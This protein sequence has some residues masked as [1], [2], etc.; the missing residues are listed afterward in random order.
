MLVN[1]WNCR[2]GEDEMLR[3]NDLF[4]G[5]G[6]MG[7]GFKQ[8]GF[9]LAGA[10][11][12]DKYAVESYGHNISPKVKQDDITTMKWHHLPYAEVWT[13]GFPC[14]DISVAGKQ[15][16]MIKG[17]TRSG[18][19]YEV[20]RLLDETREHLSIALPKI[21]LAENV[22]A[23]KKYLPEIEK[24]YAARGYKMNAQLYNSKYWG[25]PQNRERYFIIGVRDD[26]E[27]DFIFPTQQTDHVPK[28]SSILETEVDEK[29]YIDDIKATK[30]IEQA[31]NGL[32]VKQATKKGYDVAVEGDS[33]NIAHPNST[34]RR[35][36]VGKQVAQTLMTSCEQVVCVG[37]NQKNAGVFEEL[38]PTLT[39]AA[40]LG[41]GH[42][43]YLVQSVFTDK[44]NC[45]YCCDANYA[46]GTSPGDIG[47][48]RR[49]HIIDE[50]LRVRKLTPREYA[51]LQG[52]PD[53]FEF[54]C[55]NTQIYKQMGNAVTVNVSRA[56]ATAIKEF[57]EG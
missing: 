33:I 4:C 49:T 38:S 1:W 6:G 17:E 29:Y 12:F 7:L 40:G 47:K 18:L 9:R 45:S 48:G 2:N 20:M 16:G 34:T 44:D 3:V 57:L 13:F 51:R 35:G 46:K 50:N 11:D 52:F 19:F 55:S 5:A 23:V 42:I 56:I 27:K 31:I 32:K 43:A 14:Q 53:S 36:R 8:S 41:G 21:I 37:S 54:V 28:L 15:A 26:I 24:E 25:I 30:I 39:S 10:W 22:K